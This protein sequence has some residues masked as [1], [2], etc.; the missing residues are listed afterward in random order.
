MNTD[1]KKVVKYGI[2]IAAIY[3]C[4]QYFTVVLSVLGTLVGAASPL[5]LG[6]CIAY[7]L[8]ILMKCIEKVY[9]PKNKNKWIKKS[10]RGVS[11]FLAIALLILLVAL[12]IKLVVPELI[13]S[14]KLIGQEIPPFLNDVQKF[15]VT[16][17][18]DLPSMQQSI[19]NL[20]V[21]W[22]DVIKNVA[23]Y[24]IA[25]AG[26]VVSSVITVTQS[27]FGVVSQVLISTIFAIYI[28][29]HK[30]KLLRQMEN[31]LKA[32]TKE[33]IQNRVKHVFGIVNDTFSNFIIGQCTEAVIIG[34]LCAVGMWI[35][36]FP[37]AIMTGT[38]IGVTALI[39]VVGAYIGA[40][41]GAFMIF[42]VSP[43]QALFFVVFL[44]ILQQLE[45]NLIYP[46]VVG[47]SIG[48]P[49]MWVLAAVTIGGSTFGII[50]MLLGVPLAATCYKLLR[51]DVNDKLI[52]QNTNRQHRN[53]TDNNTNTTNR[54]SN[55]RKK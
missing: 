43:V 3:L 38:V 40:V 32:Y 18:A 51:E 9:F 21:D 17:L 46:K 42:T 20:K 37:Y 7:I 54:K 55:Q 22:S 1:T 44:V 41:I 36:R 48:L 31:L 15:L 13:S 6:C 29:F 30:E 52:K 16:A 39:P 5:I 8:N 35:L 49:G 27:V 34:T 11:I 23:D 45:G 4:V 10:R 19:K 50:G 33:Q 25:G 26:G 24:V 14:F 47:S 28:L 2:I 12:I 53:T